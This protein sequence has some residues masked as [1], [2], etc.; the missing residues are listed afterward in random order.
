MATIIEKCN[1]NKKSQLPHDYK[2]IVLSCLYNFV[3]DDSAY[4]MK[5]T[6]KILFILFLLMTCFFISEMAKY[7]RVQGTQIK[8]IKS[9]I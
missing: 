3:D 7:H 5:T 4:F 2:P 6:V 1:E 9:R 8:H